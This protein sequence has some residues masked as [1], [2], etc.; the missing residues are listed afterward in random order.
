MLS[1]SAPID[2][3]PLGPPTSGA[4][5]IPR[6]RRSRYTLLTRRDKAVMALMVG[7]P[8]FLCISL[9][10][11]PTVASIGLSF[12]N[13]RGITPLT[14]KNLVGVNIY[15]NLFTQYPFFWPAVWHNVLWLF[16]LTF[17][18]TPSGM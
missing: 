14:E 8:T 2:A 1:E 18:A 13:W 16:T 5:A 7:I 3:A 10:W 6:R 4:V 12:T 9:I 17:I 11:L 15:V